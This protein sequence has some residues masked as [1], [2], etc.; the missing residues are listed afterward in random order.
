MGDGDE[1]MR[2]FSHPLRSPWPI[3]EEWQVRSTLTIYPP[4]DILLL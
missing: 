3:P 4:Y 1:N 2:F